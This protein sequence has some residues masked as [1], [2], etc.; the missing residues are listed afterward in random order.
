MFMNLVQY[1]SIVRPHLVYAIGVV[2]TIQ[3]GAITIENVQRRAARLGAPD[4]GFL[5]RGSTV[6]KRGYFA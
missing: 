6:E 1:K 5:K 4:A 2:A 3:K